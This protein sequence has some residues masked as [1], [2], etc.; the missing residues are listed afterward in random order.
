MAAGTAAAVAVLSLVMLGGRFLSAEN[1]GN[2]ANI[3]G[4][5]A[6]AA[7]GTPLTVDVANA[8]VSATASDLTAVKAKTMEG[9]VYL[10]SGD[11][12][13]AMEAQF[14]HLTA[15][16]ISFEGGTVKDVDYEIDGLGKCTVHCLDDDGNRICYPEFW[17]Y[18][19]PDELAEDYVFTATATFMDGTSETK[20]FVIKDFVIKEK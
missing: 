3:F 7:D 8:S 14:E 9:E 17:V 18:V 15:I 2:P 19:D 4:M 5:T 1:G 10:I 16:T 13:V 11:D 6:Y 12:I 20:E